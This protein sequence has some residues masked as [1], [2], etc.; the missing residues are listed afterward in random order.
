MYVNFEITAIFPLPYS[1]V[2]KRANFKTNIHLDSVESFLYYLSSTN[3]KFF[4]CLTPLSFSNFLIV[5]MLSKLP[6][7]FKVLAIKLKHLVGE[8]TFADFSTSKL[9]M[10]IQIDIIIFK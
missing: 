1:R 9:S 7:M 6:I 10:A 4:I 3:R 2:K 8:A 5:F